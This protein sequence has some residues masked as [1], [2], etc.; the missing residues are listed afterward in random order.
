MD[1]IWKLAKSGVGRSLVARTLFYSS[2][3]A[4]AAGAEPANLKVKCTGLTPK[5]QVDPKVWLKISIRASELTQILGRP[6]EFQVLDSSDGRASRLEAELLATTITARVSEPEQMVAVLQELRL[7]STAHIGR[8]DGE[9]RSEMMAMMRGTGVA[10]GDRN[11]IRLLTATREHNILEVLSYVGP[12]GVRRTQQ[13]GQE[14]V[15]TDKQLK[16]QTEDHAATAQP[17]GE[18]A[19]GGSDLSSDSASSTIHSCGRHALATLHNY[20]SY[21]R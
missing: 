15:S 10:L 14:I 9:E 13:D 17:S 16:K 7:E 8:L 11:K 12:Q 6:C 4:A 5:S 3:I 2:L 18:Q 19:D 21:L 20:I 1:R